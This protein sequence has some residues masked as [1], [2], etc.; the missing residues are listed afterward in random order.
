M[1]VGTDAAD[2][3]EKQLGAFLCVL[4][5]DLVDPWLLHQLGIFGES[6]DL[7]PEGER[8]LC[9]IRLLLW[10]ANVGGDN[11]REGE[12]GVS[13]RDLGGVLVGAVRDLTTNGILG[14]KYMR[15]DGLGSEHGLVSTAGLGG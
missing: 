13:I 8:F 4:G 5:K 2:I 9:E 11:R 1:R 12:A 15:V 10:V 14:F 3:F 7:S 6:R